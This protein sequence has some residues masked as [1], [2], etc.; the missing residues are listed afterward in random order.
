MPAT[1]RRSSR[2]SSAKR[3]SK[4]RSSKRTSKRRSTCRPSLSSIKKL[5]KTITVGGKARQLY[6]GPEGGKF[7]YSSSKSH[8]RV[9]V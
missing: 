5:K 2:R 1:T 8:C 6:A 4:A 7:Y 3:S 9:Y